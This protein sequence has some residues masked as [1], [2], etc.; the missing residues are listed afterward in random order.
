MPPERW[1]LNPFMR[2]STCLKRSGWVF[3][4]WKA[5]L[6]DEPF[7]NMGVSCGRHEYQRE[8]CCQHQGQDRTQPGVDQPISRR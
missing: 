6:R 4:S 7:I 5:V 8:Q 3:D 2:V 1:M